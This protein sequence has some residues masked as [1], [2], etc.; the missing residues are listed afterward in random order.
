MI[1]IDLVEIKRIEKLLKNSS[2]IKRVFSKEEINYCEKKAQKAQ[3]YAARF[4]A[5]EA[6]YKA[7]SGKYSIA[8]KNIVVKNLQNGKP[9][10]LIKHMPKNKIKVEVSL[11][12]TENYAVAVA[13]IKRNYL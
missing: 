1:G 2:F 3:H 10:I 7:F 13:I 6:V 11:S 5:K 9:E 8:L 12:H 4:A